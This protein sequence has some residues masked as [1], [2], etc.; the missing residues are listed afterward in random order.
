MMP[1][2]AV[3]RAALGP[4]APLFESWLTHP[5]RTDNFWE[6]QRFD[7]ALNRCRVPVLLINGWQD[8]FL[9]QTLEQYRRLRERGVEVALTIGPWVHARMLRKGASTFVPE[10]LDWLTSHVAGTAEMRRRTPVRIFVIGHGWVDL[11][12]WPPVLPHRGF[13]L[14]P[15]GGLGDVAPP[16][17]AQPSSFAFD[18][19]HPTPTIGGPLLEGGGYRDDTALATRSDVVCFDGEPLTRD[20]YVIGEPLFELT[21]SADNV[22]VDVFVR[23]SEVAANGQSTNVSEGFRRFSLDSPRRRA[24][25]DIKLHAI[26]HRFQA[27]SRIRIIVAGGSHPRF[28]RNPGTGEPVATAERL[29]PATHYVHHGAGGTSQLLLPATDGSPFG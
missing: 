23:M 29:V 10:A 26:A 9:D 22:H 20:L 11:S 14:Q 28:A 17:G 15:G 6:P 5:D 19:A 8:L 4:D 16:A 2:S 7:D 21:H 3:G 18:P 12:D 24:R 13:S 1:L 27:G 25:V